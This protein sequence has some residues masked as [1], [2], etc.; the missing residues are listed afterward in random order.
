[1]R[2][3]IEE[4]NWRNFD[5]G[6]AVQQ[7]ISII[8]K[9]QFLIVFRIEDDDCGG[10]LA[11]GILHALLNGNTSLNFDIELDCKIEVMF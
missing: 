10:D 8:E 6:D 5:M 4:A 2:K 7:L 3:L 1:M 11:S 9:R